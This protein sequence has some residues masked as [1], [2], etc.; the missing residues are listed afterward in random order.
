MG[1]VISLEATH[2]ARPMIDDSPSEFTIRAPLREQLH[3]TMAPPDAS[4]TVAP[5]QSLTSVKR[6]LLAK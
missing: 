2:Q 4:H 6:V 3:M 1:A 5:Q